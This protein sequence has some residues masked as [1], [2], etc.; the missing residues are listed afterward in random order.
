[1]RQPCVRDRGVGDECLGIMASLSR[2]KAAASR[3]VAAVIESDERDSRRFDGDAARRRV[4]EQRPGRPMPGLSGNATA[5]CAST[6]PGVRTA[7]ACDRLIVEE[8]QSWCGAP[9]ASRRRLARSPQVQRA[10]VR[11]LPQTPVSTR[12]RLRGLV[13]ASI[14]HLLAHSLNRHASAIASPSNGRHRHRFQS[15]PWR[16]RHIASSR[17]RATPNDW[18][19]RDRPD[20]N[21]TR[22]REVSEP[23][24]PLRT[25]ERPARASRDAV[26][27]LA[28]STG[29]EKPCLKN[30]EEM[31]SRRAIP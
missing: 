7:A 19:S 21:D 29:G 4:F 12:N 22:L 15:A 18:Q 25:S 14:R 20:I 11:I 8:A 17:P 13:R 26:T 3:R 27:S 6:G 28:R 2:R 16:L 24:S 5:R 1:M 31:R 23:T 30:F 10:S 9:E